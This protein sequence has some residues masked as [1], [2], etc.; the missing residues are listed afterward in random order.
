MREGLGVLA[1]HT[2][3][4]WVIACI[5][6]QCLSMVFFA[7]LQQRLLKAAEPA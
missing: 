2:E 7:L 4:D 3:P 1:A 6:S 5:G